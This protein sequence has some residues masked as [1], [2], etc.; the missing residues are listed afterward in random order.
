[1]VDW[2]TGLNAPKGMALVKNTLWVAD[3]DQMVAIDI[4]EG[5]ILKSIP[6]EG[7]GF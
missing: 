1:M 7:A 4:T 2:V 3:V 6:V 5:K